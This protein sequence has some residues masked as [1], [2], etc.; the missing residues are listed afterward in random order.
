MHQLKDGDALTACNVYAHLGTLSSRSG[1]SSCIAPAWVSASMFCKR[2]ERNG[3]ITDAAHGEHMPQQ[4]DW[5]RLARFMP[6]MVRHTSQ[7]DSRPDMPGSPL[8]F[9][10]QHA[11]HSRSQIVANVL[12]PTAVSVQMAQYVRWHG[13]VALTCGERAISAT[14]LT[15]A[16][17]SF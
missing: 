9:C 6:H 5:P 11:V 4:L 10:Y 7:P 2:R 3:S 13:A 15:K 8:S 16:T 14:V 12:L 1:R 17:R